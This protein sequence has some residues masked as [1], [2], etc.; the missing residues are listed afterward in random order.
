MNH[1]PARFSP[2]EADP[3][4]MTRRA[5]AKQITYD[6]VLQAAKRLFIARGYEASTIRGIAAEAG[7]STGAVFA[8]FTDKTDLFHAVLNADLE[9]HLALVGGIVQH[10]GPIEAGLSELFSI[11]YQVQIEQLPLLQAAASLSWTEGLGGELGDRPPAD[12]VLDM[13]TEM[14]E[15]ATIRKELSATADLRLAAEMLWDCYVANYRRAIFD[16]WNL[17]QLNA[18]LA[19]QI[20]LIL[21]GARL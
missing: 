20:E 10:P 16:N 19:R 3:R 8:N 11:G 13:A 2:R 17:D 1:L 12:K 6:K 18:R 14:L 21:A 4:R 7:M 5:Q 9:A 15:R